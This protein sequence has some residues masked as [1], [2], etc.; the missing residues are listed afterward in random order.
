MTSTVAQ[1]F[2]IGIAMKINQSSQGTH[3]DPI[4]SNIQFFNFYRMFPVPPSHRDVDS[5][6]PCPSTL[7]LETPMIRVESKPRKIESVL[8]TVS[9]HL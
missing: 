3:F 4:S 9:T 7:Q 5:E 6:T 2:V 1:F 8:S